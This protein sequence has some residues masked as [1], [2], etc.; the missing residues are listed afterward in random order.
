MDDKFLRGYKDLEHRYLAML[1]AA[2]ADEPGIFAKDMTPEEKK[3]FEDLKAEITR[4]KKM[5][6]NAE[7]DVPYD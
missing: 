1:Q 2:L 5:N 7:F 3:E 6:P 4:A